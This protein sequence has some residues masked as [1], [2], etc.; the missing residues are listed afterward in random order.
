MREYCGVIGVFTSNPK[1]LMPYLYEG[2]CAVQHRGQEAVGISVFNGELKT[3]KSK[4]L[5]SESKIFELD[6]VGT[7]GIGHTRY[8][9]TGN[10]S[11]HNAH[12]VELTSKY[13]L[14]Y[15]FAFNGNIGNYEELMQKIDKQKFDT[16]C[17][18]E[19]LGYALGENLPKIDVNEHFRLNGEMIKGAFAGVMLMTGDN[20]QLIAIRDPYGFRPLC[21]GKTDDA[22]FVS[23]E[24]VAFSDSYMGGELI[25]D[26][27]PGEVV[28]I[29]ETGIKSNQV[30]SL[31]R[32]AL[33]MFEYVYFSRPDSIINNI[34]VYEAREKLGRLLARD[35]PV[36][37]DVVIPVPD[38]GRSAATGY[39]IESGIPLKEGFQKDRYRY[40]RSFILD[41]NNE[42]MS[43]AK[44]KLNPMS[45]MI[46]D[47]K[48]IV[49]DDSI[50]RGVN[51]SFVKDLKNAGAKE[52]HVR[53]SCPPIIEWCP[54][55]IDF[56]RGELIARKYWEK[57]EKHEEI[58][59]S[60]SKEI[61]ADSVYYN[62]LDNL[63][64]ALGMF[65]SDL[66]TACL[67]AEYPHK[68]EIQTKSQR[69]R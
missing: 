27:K 47:K 57:K 5:V 40:R 29:D 6:D 63:V 31:N 62:T 8:S 49:V 60:V 66:C 13:G 65:K 55:G 7:I 12:P 15:S 41:D 10:T 69:K 26:V 61:G 18:A 38:S 24:S 44:K 11:L 36:D 45:F 64:E 23:S 33:C 42:R 30:F 21:I 25:R 20:P 35:Y 14:K 22:Y 9:T 19:V 46:K 2:L 53:I 50:V 17:D 58:C 1:K 43:V 4:G 59:N 28:T 51:A 68:I 67:T 52:V 16:T 37:G 34:P 39:A 48:V 54:Y 3:Y 56:Y 32:Q